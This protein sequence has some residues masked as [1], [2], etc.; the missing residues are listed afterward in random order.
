TDFDRKY[1]PDR[2][3][4]EAGPN[5][6]VWR[7]YRDRVT[8]LDEDLMQGWNST[9]DVLLIFA[10][11]FSAI[12]TAF[13]IEATTQLQHDYTQYTAIGVFAVLAALN[14]TVAAPSSLPDFNHVQVASRSRWINGIWFASLALAL[15][16]ALLAILVKQW[17]VEYGSR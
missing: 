6:R 2:H 1:P 13:V 8:E 14:G 5:A 15:I 11:L 17:L 16:D 7:V 3:G 9:L 12:V 10:G 4:D